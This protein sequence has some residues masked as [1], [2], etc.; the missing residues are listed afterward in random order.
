MATMT[1]DIK[2]EESTGM[3]GMTLL[4]VS[5]SAL[6]VSSL[7]IYAVIRGRAETWPPPGMPAMP[8]G[9]VATTAI[10]ILSSATMFAATHSI[11]RGATGSFKA[12]IAITLA[13]GIGFLAGQGYVWSGLLKSGVAAGANLYT[14]SFFFMSGLHAAHVIG[15]LIFLSIVTASAMA[16]KY[17]AGSHSQ[18]KYCSVYW[19]FL[20][21]AWMV[22]FSALFLID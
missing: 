9:A 6:F 8:G 16:G 1:A 2:K 22:L 3:L 11:R 12:F 10:L 20:D 15:G 17:T 14:F 13:L 4:I 7:V 21:V 5:L 19:H 18:V